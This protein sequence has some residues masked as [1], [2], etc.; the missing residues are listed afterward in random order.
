MS[1]ASAA[2]RA[3]LSAGSVS[4]TAGWGTATAAVPADDGRQ[5][6][7][8]DVVDLAG[9]ERAG[10]ARRSRCRSRGS[11]PAAARTRRRRARRGAASRADAARI[12]ERSAL[13]RPVWPADMSAPRR[14]TCCRGYTGV[15]TRIVVVLPASVSSTMT[16]AS[17]PGGIGAPVA[18]S[19]HSPRAI[20]RA[21][22]WPVNTRSTQRERRAARRARRRTCPPRRPRSRPSPRGRTA[23]RRWRR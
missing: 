14:P 1:S 5:R 21:G 18:I 23:A 7:P 20:A 10:R 6:E 19:M 3:A 13:E 15:R 11:R 4:G 17:A 16:T 22:T 8:V 2:S 12:Q 9:R